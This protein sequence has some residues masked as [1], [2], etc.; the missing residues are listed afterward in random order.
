MTAVGL[1]GM[2]QGLPW[3]L[4]MGGASASR[5]G[6]RGWARRRT[7]NMQVMGSPADAWDAGDGEA[8]SVAHDAVM[9]RKWTALP[10]A[11]CRG[12]GGAAG[13]A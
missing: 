9:Q 1:G 5:A 8:L 10:V 4:G 6:C 13:R 7:P 3:M 12:W 2:N 11:G